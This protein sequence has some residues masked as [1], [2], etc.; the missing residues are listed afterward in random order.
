MKDIEK[1]RVHYKWLTVKNNKAFKI[2][3]HYKM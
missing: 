1:E 2:K 3:G